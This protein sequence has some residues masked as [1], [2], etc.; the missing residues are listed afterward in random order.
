MER[1]NELLDEA[2]RQRN[3]ASVAEIVPTITSKLTINTA[4]KN[5]AWWGMEDIVEVLLPYADPKA[6]DSAP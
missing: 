6:F 1:Q 2:I 3:T 4:L 5:A